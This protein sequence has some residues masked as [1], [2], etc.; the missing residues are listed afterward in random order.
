VTTIAHG[1]AK[2]T[3]P[4]RIETAR[5]T[6]GRWHRPLYRDSGYGTRYACGW[7]PRAVGVWQAIFETPFPDEPYCR[8]CWPDRPRVIRG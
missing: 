7:N 2:P 8:K 1:F 4:N 5:L 6:S 3:D